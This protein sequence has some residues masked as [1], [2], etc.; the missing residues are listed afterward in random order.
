MHS[1]FEAI[2]QQ[3]QHRLYGYAYYSLRIA[4]DAEDVVQEAFLRLW[5]N[6][7]DID[8]P[9][10]GAWL[11]RVTR[12]LVIDRV[13]KNKSGFPQS[14]V[15]IDEIAQDDDESRHQEVLKRIVEQSIAGLDDPYRTTLILREIQGLSYQEIADIL[16][17]S[18]D[19]V[20]TDLF[21]GKGKLREIVKQHALYHSELLA[22]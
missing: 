4:E 2:K 15:D 8:L 11:M 6:W 5:E 12:N 20:K 17:I 1:Q 22:G 10:V 3:Y 9:Q 21:R 13:R 18:V 14:E 19:Q 16:S 7:Q